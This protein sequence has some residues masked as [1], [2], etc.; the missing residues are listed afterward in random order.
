[1]ETPS[2]D[3]EEIHHLALWMPNWVGDVVLALPA[4]QSLRRR[5]PNTRITVIVRPPADE[6]LLGHPA[7]D[8]VIRFPQN[9]GDGILAQLSYARGLS[10]YGFDLG[11]VFPNSIHS[12]LMLMLA[13]ARFRLGY[14]TDGRG[15]FLTHPLPISRKARKTEYR[16]NYF[17]NILAPLNPEPLPDRHDPIWPENGKPSLE[18]TLL[19]VGV[20]KNDFFVTVHPGTSK[21]ERAWHAERFGIFCQKLTKEF[22]MKIILLGTE[23]EEALLAKIREFCPPG[24]TVTVPRLNLLE[25][26]RVLEASRL[27]IGNDSGMMHL[28]SLVGTPVVGIF[29]PGH[30]GTSGPYLPPE[31]QEIVTHHYPCSP[32]RQQFFK[33]CKPSPHNKPYCLED[34]S[35]KDVSEAV[36]RLVKK[37]E[38]R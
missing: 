33:E 19:K 4:V 34:I 14:K 29:G 13:G 31:K 35:V 25:I 17:Y 23:K 11:V 36:E 12:A 24:M 37:L 2:L 22:R 20:D 3:K 27:F 9:E 8:S 26:M 16:V 21:P 32:C 30:P 7:V 15:M 5:Y 1:M 38:I 28:A 6:L 18:E 10:K